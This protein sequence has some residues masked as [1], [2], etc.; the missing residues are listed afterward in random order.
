M[1]QYAISGFYRPRLMIEN[2]MTDPNLEAADFSKDRK[3]IMV[4]FDALR[5][6][7]VE[8]DDYAAQFTKLDG[9]AD[10]AYHGKKISIFKELMEKEPENCFHLPAKTALPTKTT[11]KMKVSLSGSMHNVF[12]FNEHW[13]QLDNLAEDNIIN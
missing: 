6:D 1:L 4:T 2:K 7:V 13:G 8:F 11:I 3:I 5:E 9:K 12:E 10:Y